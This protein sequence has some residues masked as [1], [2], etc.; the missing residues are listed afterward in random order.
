MFRSF[1]KIY[2]LEIFKIFELA[3][4]SKNLRILK[5]YLVLE[6]KLP[7]PS[8]KNTLIYFF[9]LIYH[10]WERI[11]CFCQHHEP[12][13]KLELAEKILKIGHTREFIPTKCFGQPFA[14]VNPHETQ[15][16]LWPFAKVYTRVSLYPRNF[17][18]I[19]YFKTSSWYYSSEA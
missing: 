5:V 1:A 4:F 19:K 13:L 8:F 3:K 6:C 16:W 15:F 18:P 9:C 14:K 10:R 12:N 11:L 2:T 17:L 7:L